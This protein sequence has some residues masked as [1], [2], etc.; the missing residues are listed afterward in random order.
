M[1]SYVIFKDDAKRDSIKNSMLNGI[2]RIKTKIKKSQPNYDLEE[3][4]RDAELIALLF[5]NKD[6]E[7]YVCTE[8]LVTIKK[9]QEF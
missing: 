3:L 1:N 9:V 6:T 2:V 5:N 8:D 7:I 4:V